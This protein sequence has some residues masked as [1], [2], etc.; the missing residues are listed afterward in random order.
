MKTILAQNAKNAL[1]DVQIE[2]TIL[3]FLL[4]SLFFKSIVINESLSQNTLE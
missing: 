1:S 3:H 2:A 4:I